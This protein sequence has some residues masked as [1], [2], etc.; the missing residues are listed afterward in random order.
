MNLNDGSDD[1]CDEIEMPEN[2]RAAV[3][4]VHLSYPS[5][6]VDEAGRFVHD[7]GSPL[8]FMNPWH[9]S[10][11]KGLFSMDS[12]QQEIWGLKPHL[13]SQALCSQ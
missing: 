9:L 11:G 12:Q 3:P 4:D 6:F 2:S 13:I 5:N 10:T 7:D 1:S 8:G